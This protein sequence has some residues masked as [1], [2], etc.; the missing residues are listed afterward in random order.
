MGVWGL[1]LEII[2]GI[3]YHHRPS[4]SSDKE[5]DITAA[6]HCANI[7]ELAKEDR[8]NLDFED[9]FDLNFIKRLGIEDRIEKWREK[10]IEG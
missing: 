6:V 5:F 4:E 7:I 9:A 1:P 10:F 2:E 3:L 8:L